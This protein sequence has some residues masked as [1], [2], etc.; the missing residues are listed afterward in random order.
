[1]YPL[2]QFC[3]TISRGVPVTFYLLAVV[4][5]MLGLTT[6]TANA[7]ESTEKA[8]P[9]EA[10]V[11]PA[12]VDD[13]L[14]EAFGLQ[15]HR[16]YVSAPPGMM[17]GVEER[18]YGPDGDLDYRSSGQWFYSSKGFNKKE[19]F[20]GI[21]DPNALVLE[22][23]TLARK[24]V[25]S[26]GGTTWFYV[27]V[28]RE[29]F[30]RWEADP[31]TLSKGRDVVLFERDYTTSELKPMNYPGRDSDEVDHDEAMKHAAESRAKFA[32]R[33]D[34]EERKKA[35]PVR[36]ELVVRLQAEPAKLPS[37][38]QGMSNLRKL[39]ELPIANSSW[40]WNYRPGTPRR[41]YLW[42]AD[43]DDAAQGGE[44]SDESD[45]PADD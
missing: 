3:T 7:D 22:R 17:L 18:W 35:E 10:K 21:V 4:L 6:A 32:S 12:P 44:Q 39:S 1:M 34:E 40:T 30:Q 41:W 20:I 31:F 8:A 26:V 9:N 13:V 37:D 27:P 14:A 38:M 36:V 2:T 45:Q 15:V 5:I 29:S 43:T 19:I 11:E 33:Y 28:S 23:H 16:F 42:S 25:S 24:L